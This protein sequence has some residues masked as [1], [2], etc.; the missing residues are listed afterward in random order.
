MPS[1]RI[2]K[3][4]VPLFL[5][6][7]LGLVAVGLLVAA[8]QIA[9]FTGRFRLSSAL[10]APFLVMLGVGLVVG[11][12]REGCSHCRAALAHS[13]CTLALDLAPHADQAVQR[14]ASGDFRPLFAL[15]SAPVARHDALASVA[16]SYC[17]ECRT[18][19]RL[20]S[21]QQRPN[22]DGT[23]GYLETTTVYVASAEVGSIVAAMDAR[24]T[25]R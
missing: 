19:A 7:G 2:S 9:T 13:Q 24:S 25:T 4:F 15:M 1:R 5:F 14:A 17:P 23:T 10:I 16:A 3:V 12:F 20:V 18:V 6:I 8:L 21:A 22:P 11:C